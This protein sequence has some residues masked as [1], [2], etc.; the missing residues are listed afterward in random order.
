MS[1]RTRSF[2]FPS[3]CIGLLVIAASSSCGRAVENAA[4]G[5]TAP[6]ATSSFGA[7]VK[8]PPAPPIDWDGPATDARTTSLTAVQAGGVL[9]FQV[10]KPDF[11]ID[12]V[13]VESSQA[14]VPPDATFLILRYRF[15][16]PNGF[17]GDTRVVV[18]ERPTNLPSDWYTSVLA[19]PPGR[20]QDFSTVSV[21]GAR[22]LVNVSP[23]GTTARVGFIRNGVMFDLSG[24]AVSP[25]KAVELA[26]QL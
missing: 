12:P 15:S 14:G 10:K 9:P 4:P 5:A 23:D 2:S 25:A 16:D 3:V 21:S 1:P 19:D 11:G 7:D 8:P 13:L 22:A 20:P 26:A 17:N 24:P 6:T 18:E